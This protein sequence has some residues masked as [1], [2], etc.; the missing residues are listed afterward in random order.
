MKKIFTLMVIL[1]F[2]QAAFSES[3]PAA[4]KPS[5]KKRCSA[6]FSVKKISSSVLMR[7][8]QLEAF[9]LDR[10]LLKKLLIE[11]DK[12]IKRNTMHQLRQNFR[13]A[14]HSQIKTEPQK[15]EIERLLAELIYARNN[16]KFFLK[17]ALKRLEQ[18]PSEEK[19][20]IFMELNDAVKK[21]QRK[22]S[23]YIETAKE[24]ATLTTAKELVKAIAEA[25][26]IAK[27][28]TAK[29]IIDTGRIEILVLELKAIAEKAAAIVR[30]AAASAD[31]DAAKEAAV[32]EKLNKMLVDRERLEIIKFFIVIE[33]IAKAGEEIAKV[34]TTVKAI[35]S[36]EEAQALAKAEAELAEVTAEARE[37]I[38]AREKIVEGRGLRVEGSN[39]GY[40]SLHKLI[41]RE[42]IIAAQELA[43]AIAIISEI[44]G[45]EVKEAA[46]ILSM[47][48]IIET[49]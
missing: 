29:D 41:I 24:I 31:V 17:R 46:N 37:I 6:L 49:M 30:I 44:A 27:E 14:G 48:K 21:A 28:I 39:L 20:H 22:D 5:F 15:Q 11:R 40:K 3:P 7:A 4:K 36:A 43:E 10:F 8:E 2:A 12:Q 16:T 32:R 35:A 9:L 25:Q 26:S 13:K 34:I 18:E 23:F 33:N 47:L 19:Q 1:V 38:V 45:V 42:D